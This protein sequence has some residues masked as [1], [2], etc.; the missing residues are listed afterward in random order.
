V[1]GGVD[2]RRVTVNPPGDAAAK[3]TL[4]EAIAAGTVGDVGERKKVPQGSVGLSTVP[5]NEEKP[6]VI[7]P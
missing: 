2:P 6:E 4:L 1:A 7:Y 3:E 5:Q